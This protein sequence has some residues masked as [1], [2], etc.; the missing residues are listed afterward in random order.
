MLCHTLDE[1]T[2]SLW[3]HI[4]AIVAP[5]SY[6]NARERILMAKQWHEIERFWPSWL[7]LHVEIQKGTDFNGQMVVHG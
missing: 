7:L 4:L 3:S 6:G 2:L 5:A 1:G